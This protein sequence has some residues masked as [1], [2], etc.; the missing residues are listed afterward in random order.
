VW[1]AAFL[2]SNDLVE[3]MQAFAE[4]RPPRFTGT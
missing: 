1:N 4:K 2:A 3:A